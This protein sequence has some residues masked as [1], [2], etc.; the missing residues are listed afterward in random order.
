MAYSGSLRSKTFPKPAAARSCVLNKKAGVSRKEQRLNGNVHRSVNVEN[1][2]WRGK[3]KHLTTLQK[4]C[5][6]LVNFLRELHRAERHTASIL[7]SV[8]RDSTWWPKGQTGPDAGVEVKEVGAQ[9]L[10]RWPPPVDH[11]VTTSTDTE[12]LRGE[13]WKLNGPATRVQQGSSLKFRHALVRNQFVKKFMH[14][15]LAEHDISLMWKRTTR[16]QNVWI[17]VVSL[18]HP[19]QP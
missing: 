19:R 1:L 17:R 10:E 7:Q 5:R 11:G 13:N 2:G 18:G 15:E 9:S 8:G 6:R 3:L 16:W 12:C 4:N 14:E